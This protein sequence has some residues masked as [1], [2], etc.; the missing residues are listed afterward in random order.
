MVKRLYIQ[1]IKQFDEDGIRLLPKNKYTLKEGTVRMGTNPAE[2]YM[3]RARKLYSH[4][5]VDRIILLSRKIH[6]NN[7]EDFAKEIMKNCG[8]EWKRLLNDSLIKEAEFTFIDSLE[9]IEEKEYSRNIEIIQINLVSSLY[10]TAEYYLSEINKNP[11]QL[12][13]YLVRMLAGLYPKEWRQELP[14]GIPHYV[15]ENI[16]KLITQL[17]DDKALTAYF[18]FFRGLLIKKESDIEEMLKKLE[19]LFR[20]TTDYREGFEDL[21]LILRIIHKSLSSKSLF[22][23]LEL[24][25]EINNYFLAISNPE[26]YI[27]MLFRQHLELFN[28]LQRFHEANDLQDKLY[29]LEGSRRKIRESEILVENKFVDPFKTFYFKILKKWMDITFEEGG[30]LLSGT[31]LETNLQTKRITWKEELLVSLSVKNVGIATAQ[32]IEIIL[33]NSADY[34]ISGHQNQVISTLPRN[35]SED[36]EFHIHPKKKESI[37]LHFSVVQS[38]N[39]IEVS[40]TLFFV[41]KEKFIQIP[42]PYNFTRPAEDEMFFDR[43]DL[44]YWI[45]TNMKKPTIYQN[46]LIMGQRRTGKT[47]FLKELK[48]RIES[49]HYCVYIDLEEYPDLSDIRL[50]FEICQELHHIIPDTS[51]PQLIEFERK[52]YMAFGD[53][54]RSL[55]SQSSDQKKI[56]LIFD[57]FD[58]IESKIEEGLSKSGFLLFLRAFLQRNSRVTAVIGGKFDFNKLFSPEWREFFTI[59]NPKIIGAL[60]EESATALVIE[61]VKDFLQ[62]DSYAVKKILDFSGRIP[63]YMQ[64]I[65]H[66]LVNYLNKRKQNFA[67]SEDVNITIL[68][69]A[70]EMAEPTL[71]LTW[72]EFDPAEKGILS[73]LS[74]LKV[75]HKRAIQLTE[76]E[77]YLKRKDVKKKTWEVISLLGALREKGIVTKS[78]ESPSFYDFA[79]LLLEDWIADHGS[80]TGE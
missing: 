27:D 44:F 21:R 13:K 59:F 31:S 28:L 80:F 55:P 62:Y 65:C 32:N 54:V 56:I 33:D 60:D 75:Q 50:L 34:T 39:V 10:S 49:D 15:P 71:R 5:M 67:D 73:A 47:S 41:E 7:L 4:E 43:E 64:L 58:K 36:V 63:F 77:A 35:R 17:T 23:I 29:F 45:E 19:T 6:Q 53:Y 26:Q 25:N 72:E 2:F 78:G 79:I 69:E 42:N 1:D 68:N 74:R 70:R 24:K 52:S 9:F 66:T 8:T 14:D 12:P 37:N 18:D 48:K 46:V 40:D 3:E 57:E 51:P 76:L 16:L 38:N 11:N 61:P 20:S 22:A 30:K